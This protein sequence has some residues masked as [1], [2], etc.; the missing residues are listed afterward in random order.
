MPTEL[1]A[2]DVPVTIDGVSMALRPTWIAAQQISRN[3]GGISPA[4]EKVVSVDFEAIVFIVGLGLGY[5]PDRAMPQDMP[6][7]IWRSGATDATGRLVQQVVR[8]LSI[9]SAGGKPT[10]AK[11]GASPPQ[12]S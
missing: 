4:I 2:G 10:V 7:K 12:S 3:Y 5:G 11:E 6:E 9:L 8:Y 1:G